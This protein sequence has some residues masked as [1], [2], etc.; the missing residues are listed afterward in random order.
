M[1][2]IASLCDALRDARRGKGLKQSE[3]A[4]QL[5]MSQAAISQ[6]ERGN[7]S[8]VSFETIQR[9]A[10][11]LGVE[12]PAPEPDE[13]DAVALKYC[14][15]PDCL[16]NVA[17]GGGGAHRGPIVRPRMTRAAKDETTWCG[18]CGGILM[19]HCR[20]EECGR[21]VA[22]GSF[23]M[24]CGTAYVRPGQEN[25]G[26]AERERVLRLTRPRAVRRVSSD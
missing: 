14:E 11:A 25:A 1:K 26:H 13:D 12:V 18:E 10:R 6:L 21:P 3:L 9:V 22:E 2:D 15:H 20:N 19:D 24:G 17:Y 5:D 7:T 16:A 4:A 23:C 8:A